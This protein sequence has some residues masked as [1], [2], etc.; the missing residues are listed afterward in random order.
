MSTIDASRDERPGTS[1]EEKSVWIQL[2]SL[3][4]CLG[5]Y[6]YCAVA[7]LGAGVR[8]LIP[9]APVFAV[10]VVLLILINIAGHIAAAL[11]TRPEPRDERDRVIEWRAESGSQ[12]V[13][14]LGVLLA[15]N[16]M[17]LDVPNV[18]TAH[19]LLLALFVAELL[20]CG[21]QLAY[22]RRGL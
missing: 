5:G 6:G 14:G 11:V 16:A 15:L 8:A 12:W 4:V 10:A 17:V 22:Y 2:V 9:F 20:R 19:G 21:R 18:W 7:M 13:L 3:L 1:F